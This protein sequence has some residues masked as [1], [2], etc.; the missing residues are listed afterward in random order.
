[1]FNPVRDGRGNVVPHDEP[2]L[3]NDDGLVRIIRND[4]T[5]LCD[6]E[7]RGG[8]R[9]SSAA[10]SATSGDRIT[11]CPWISKNH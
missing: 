1:M 5:H 10:F 9:I 4:D 3:G 6:D 11:V 8:K 2:A 7:N